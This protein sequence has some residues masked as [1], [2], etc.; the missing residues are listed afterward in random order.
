MA[1]SDYDVIATKLAGLV[2]AIT[3]YRFIPG[4][5]KERVGLV[6]CGAA[7]SWY[8][9]QYVSDK[10]GLPAGFAGYLTGFFG[11]SIA[12][13]IHEWVR[14]APTDAM[15][16]ICLDWLKRLFGKSA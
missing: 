14:A 7:L 1:I 4:T 9:S 12:A 3:S 8:G 15:W 13:K 16:Q 2:G 10:T 6:A 5:K 11:M